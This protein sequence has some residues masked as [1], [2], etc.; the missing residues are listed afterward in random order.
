MQRGVS[1]RRIVGNNEKLQRL[2]RRQLSNS[3]SDRDQHNDAQVVSGVTNAVKETTG[4]LWYST[5]EAQR[6]SCE[7]AT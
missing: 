3:R 4:N 1:Q 5:G 7:E 6:F 2:K